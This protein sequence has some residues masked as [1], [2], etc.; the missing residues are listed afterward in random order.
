MD[1]SSQ[2]D[3]TN[4]FSLVVQ[5]QTLLYPLPQ[6]SRAIRLWLI[7]SFS[8]VSALCRHLKA[9]VAIIKPANY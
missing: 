5:Q 4:G 2:T 9:T 1:E 7:L 3:E 8:S 6:G